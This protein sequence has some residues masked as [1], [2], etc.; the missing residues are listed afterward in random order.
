[1]QGNLQPKGPHD[2]IFD[3][4]SGLADIKTFLAE[5]RTYSLKTVRQEYTA[6]VEKNLVNKALEFTGGNR[7]KAAAVLEISYKSL[8]NKMKLFSLA[9]KVS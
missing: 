4:G 8:L 2:N 9:D 5:T 3:N 7:K 6:A 1:V